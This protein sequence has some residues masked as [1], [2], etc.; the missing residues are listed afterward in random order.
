MSSTRPATAGGTVVAA[1]VVGATALTTAVVVPESMSTN[2]PVLCPFRLVTGLPCPGC[3]LTRSWVAIGHGD[4][5]GAFAYNAFG[6]LSM[7]FVASMV[8][9]V[10]AVALTVPR[11]LSRIESILRHP[12]VWTVAGLWVAYGIARGID[13]VANTGWFPPVS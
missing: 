2:G 3:G 6:P 13:A 5:H 4:L 7:A 9:L 8:V 1:A 12:V 11:R 10:A